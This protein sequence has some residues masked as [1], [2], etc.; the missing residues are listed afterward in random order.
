MEKKKMTQ[1]KEGKVRSKNLMKPQVMEEIKQRILD[2]VSTQKKYR[3][4]SFSAQK[5]AEM[6]GTNTRYVSIVINVEFGQNYTSF[7][8]KFRITE[9]KKRLA[10]PRY[11]QIKIE[12]ISKMVGFAN[13]QSFYASFTRIVGMTPR[14]YKMSCLKKK[15]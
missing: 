12:D 3:D 4:H 13:R 5:L 14:E 8:N 9:A 11:R 2:I 10:D 1:K 6:L 15:S 7:I